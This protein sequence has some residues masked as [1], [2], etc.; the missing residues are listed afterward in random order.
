MRN[1]YDAAERLK[2]F[3]ALQPL[4]GLDSIIDALHP[5]D[6]E[7]HASLRHAAAEVTRLQQWQ[8]PRVNCAY[9]A[10]LCRT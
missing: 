7:I 3:V 9:C 10:A 2:T 8:C 1:A 5:R 6:R 4:R